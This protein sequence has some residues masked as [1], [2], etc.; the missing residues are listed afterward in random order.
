MRGSL[1]C[2]FSLFFISLTL[3]AI[4]IQAGAAGWINNSTDGLTYRDYNTDYD[5]LQEEHGI[6]KV[7]FVAQVDI[8]FN[9]ATS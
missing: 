2:P 3:H 5:T 1:N 7:D 8:I 6:L 4:S 9:C